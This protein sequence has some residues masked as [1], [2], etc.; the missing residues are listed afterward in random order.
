MAKGLFDMLF[1]S[2]FDADWVGRRGEKLTERELKLVNFLGRKGKILKNAYIPKPNGETSEIDVLY[3]SQK[4]IFVIESKNYSGWIFGDEKSQN[5]TAMLPNKQKNTFYNPIKQ[6]KTHIKW[7]SEFLKNDIPLF[8]LIVFSERCEL[9]KV[10]VETKEIKVI[11]RDYIYA[12]IRNMWDNLADALNDEQVQAVYNLLSPLTNA[13]AAT[14]AAHIENINKKITSQ[15]SDGSHISTDNTKAKTN[16]E[17]QQNENVCANN[18]ATNNEHVT[19]LEIDTSANNIATNTLAEKHEEDAQLCPKCNSDLVKRVAKK[20]AN[21]GGSFY[22]CSNFPKCRYIKPVEQEQV[23]TDKT[24]LTVQDKSEN[25]IIT[26]A[27]KE[28]PPMCPKC[29]SE[30][31][32]RVAKK[33]ANAGGSFY[34]CSNYPKCKYVQDTDN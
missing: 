2:I 17:T 18:T 5:W 30:L 3:I 22:G 14:K 7:L 10:T 1:D 21:T 15:K 20:G 27:A 9:K 4:G 19:A 26:Y 16:K 34:G 11:K 23:Q 28:K 12:T 31:V 24:S 13:D 8:S 32:K 25:E 29:N 33:G 6:N